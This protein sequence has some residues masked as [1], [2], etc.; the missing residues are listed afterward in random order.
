[1]TAKV[2][3]TSIDYVPR[4]RTEHSFNPESIKTKIQAAIT[5]H[6]GE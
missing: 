2:A 1:V 5:A 3:E 4:R 6:E